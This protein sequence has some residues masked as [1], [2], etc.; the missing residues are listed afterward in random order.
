MTNRHRQYPSCV[1]WPG[2][3]PVCDPRQNYNC[4]KPA[5][6][7]YVKND[8]STRCNCPRQ[9]C[10]LTYDYTVSQAEFSDFYIRF[11]K[12]FFKINQSTNALKYDY[13]LLE[14]RVLLS[15]DH[16]LESKTK[17]CNKNGV[18]FSEPR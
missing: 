6:I 12:G 15:I 16:F 17:S 1:V 5:L 9:C 14:V 18:L 8:E 11:A 13:C 2:E 10:R 4:L 3:A 7:D